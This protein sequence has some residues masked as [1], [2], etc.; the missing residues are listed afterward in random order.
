[1]KLQLHKRNNMKEPEIDISYSTITKPLNRV[2]QYIQQQ[3]YTVAGIK[4]NTVYQI[5][6][7]EILYFEIVDRKTF[8]YTLSHTYECKEKILFLEQ[9]LY[10][11]TIVRIGKSVLLNLSALKC[12]KPYPN[13]RLLVELNNGEYLI[14]SRK[15]IPDLQER[16]RGMYYA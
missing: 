4:E 8:L 14:V 11:T 2:I 13:H 12:V 3:E 1:M 5:P 16:I 9:A 15:F 7:N 6:L 10:G